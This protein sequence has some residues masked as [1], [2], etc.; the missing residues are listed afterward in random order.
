MV[1]TVPLITIV[2]GFTPPILAPDGIDIFPSSPTLIAFTD[3]ATRESPDTKISLTY[4]AFHLAP[5]VAPMSYVSFCEG[6][7]CF[8]NTIPFSVEAE[9]HCVG[10]N[11]SPFP[12]TC[13]VYLEKVPSLIPSKSPLT[14]VPFTFIDFTSTELKLASLALKSALLKVRFPV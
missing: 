4:K 9:L 10:S 12:S 6:T 8:E 14:F 13:G 11:K 3:P 2:P 7:I 5:P 1:A